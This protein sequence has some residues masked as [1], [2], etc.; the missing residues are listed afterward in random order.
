MK[1]VKLGFAVFTIFA[2]ASGV[3]LLTTGGIIAGSSNTKSAELE[4]QAYVY[5][6]ALEQAE[7][8]YKAAVATADQEYD[9]GIN[10]LGPQPTTDPTAFAAWQAGKDSLIAIKSAAI[11]VAEAEYAAA[12]DTA[13]YE[14]NIAVLN[15]ERNYNDGGEFTGTYRAANTLTTKKV[16]FHTSEHADEAVTITVLTPAGKLIVFGMILT[17][18]GLG[19]GIPLLLLHL[20]VI[21]GTKEPKTAVAKKTIT[22]QPK[23]APKPELEQKKP[24]PKPEPKPEPKPTPKPEP[25]K[26]PEPEPEVETD[27]EEYGDGGE[28][29]NKEYE[30]NTLGDSQPDNFHIG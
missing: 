21:G 8:T 27:T 15:V 3:A 16:V 2:L 13:S 12:K 26:E 14:Y 9:D 29:N 30:I 7:K 23:P 5:D 6:Y 18:V 24:A 28:D 1:Y 20:G 25:K 19:I 10:A 17:L 22:E 4:Y 11:K